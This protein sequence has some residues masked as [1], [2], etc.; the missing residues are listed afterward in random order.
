[1]SIVEK[2]LLV[3]ER[4]ITRVYII[5]LFYAKYEIVGNGRGICHYHVCMRNFSCMAEHRALPAVLT[6]IIN[7]CRVSMLLLAS[8]MVIQIKYGSKKYRSLA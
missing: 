1:M 5:T 8:E 2:G 6:V 3:T 4:E 7:A